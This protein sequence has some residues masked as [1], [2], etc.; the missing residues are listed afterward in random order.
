MTHGHSSSNVR[1]G[2][3][4]HYHQQRRGPLTSACQ[5]RASVGAPAAIINIPRHHRAEDERGALPAPCGWRRQP[6]L[7]PSPPFGRPVARRAVHRVERARP[8][9][10]AL[11]RAVL[12]R[13]HLELRAP[14]QREAEQHLVEQLL[15]VEVP[16]QLAATVC[17]S[18]RVEMQGGNRCCTLTPSGRRPARSP[19]PLAEDIAWRRCSCGSC[20]GRGRS[21][22][23]GSSALAPSR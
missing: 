19:L 5:A 14:L 17:V 8:Q 23:A 10:E 3:H 12:R 15:V 1:S 7:P 4:S 9:P 20:S 18:A 2:V 6:V 16:V 21:V 11:L 13:D 22:R